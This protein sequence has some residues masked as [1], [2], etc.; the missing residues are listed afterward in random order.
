MCAANQLYREI[1]VDD[2][3]RNTIVKGNHPD[4]ASVVA[5][6][7]SVV[8]GM[9]QL[10]LSA[11]VS[12]SE[13]T[14][15]RLQFADMCF[16]G[17]CRLV[18]FRDGYTKDPTWWVRCTGVSFHCH[19]HM[20]RYLTIQDLRSLSGLASLTLSGCAR[21]S[22]GKQKMTLQVV[23][24]DISMLPKAATCYN[25]L[26]LPP[27]PN[28]AI[29]QQVTAVASESFAVHMPILLNSV[30]PRQKLEFAAL[31]TDGFGFA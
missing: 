2:W 22:N 31:E 3:E 28:E 7:W 14:N 8:R 21:G 10:T 16:A 29:M 11:L 23:R 6:F 17:F 13:S 12:Q 1:D 5:R 30:L 19:A 26:Q 18:A 27:Y 20:H 9:D 24:W 25:A 4:T 15:Y